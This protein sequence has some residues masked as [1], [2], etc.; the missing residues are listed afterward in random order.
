MPKRTLV[1]M[2]QLC[3]RYLPHHTSNYRGLRE[4]L[5]E[6]AEMIS[7][8][9]RPDMYGEG[10]LV[11]T[12]EAE[13]AALLGKESVV[14]MPTGTMAQQILL[15]IIA[16]RTNK[17]SVVFHPTCHLELHEQKA[18]RRL[19]NLQA[20]LVGDAENLLKPEDV[21]AVKESFSSV[22]L[23]LPQREIGGQ[24]PS[25][26]DLQRLTLW[27]QDKGIHTH[28]DGAR[29]WQCTPFYQRDLAE[30]SAPFDSVY[31]SFYKI[32]GGI[33]G[34]ALCGPEDLIQEARLWRHRHGGKL[35]AMYPMILSAQLG[36]KKHLPKIP[37]YVAKAQSMAASLCELPGITVNPNPPQINM[38]HLYLE[39]TQVDLENA[40]QI[41]AEED[42]VFL[43]HTL[44]PTR[45]AGVQ[46]L[47]VTV[48]DAALELSDDEIQALFEK[49]IHLGHTHKV[50]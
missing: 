43:F 44:R 50:G 39:G 12:F 14:F 10:E 36:L 18:Y 38:M 20:I 32:L 13:I 46:K 47:E 28:M 30:I 9:L 42:Q 1:E 21:F 33:A 5:L 7:P 3:S 15:R 6:L 23:E 37:M 48:G 31:V 11:Q 25:W 22:L 29:L 45:L 41:I 24:L 40:A 35:F 2:Q 17:Q 49:L 34:A 27:A 16:D 26:E 4:H 19:H 8:D